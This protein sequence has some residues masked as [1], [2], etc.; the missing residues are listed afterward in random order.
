MNSIEVVFRTK[1][2]IH[3]PDKRYKLLVSLMRSDRPRH[4][5]FMCINCGKVVVEVNNCEVYGLDDFYDPDT[6]ANA[7]V[8]M[9][10][11]GS[12]RDNVPCPY[13]YFFRLQ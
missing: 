7:S 1:K 12:T 4:W 5:N 10:C 13:S 3:V 6:V 2:I 11:K 8:G 9:H